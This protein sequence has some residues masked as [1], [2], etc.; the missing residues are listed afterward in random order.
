[1]L[2]CLHESMLPNFML[3]CKHEGGSGSLLGNT[4]AS[5]Y[6]PV[7][8]NEIIFVIIPLNERRRAVKKPSLEDLLVNCIPR[9]LLLA[10]EEGLNAG[11]VRAFQASRGADPGH[12]PH[13]LGQNRHFQMNEAYYR[14]LEGNGA[15]PT[16][17]KGSAIITG[18]AGVFTLGRLNT[19][20]DVWASARRSQTRRHMALVNRSI[21]PLVQADLFATVE[22][23]KQAVAFF[24]ATFSS[25]L[26]L[27][28]EMP[29]H[30]EIAVPNRAL[31]KWL[32]KESLQMFL[33]RYNAP[34]NT[35]HDGASPKLKANL[36]TKKDGTQE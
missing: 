26:D 14:A 32:F 5:S 24:V 2:L 25:S 4:E 17:I 27:Q 8:N 33:Q 19:R 30:I 18:S 28:P 34:A 13:V 16:P 35:Q 20:E 9:E 23:P 3:A 21:E 12:L 15:A 7:E 10:V 29:T 22:D 31:N 1:M 6:S 11:A 36:R